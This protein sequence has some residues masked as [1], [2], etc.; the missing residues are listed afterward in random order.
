MPI[1]HIISRPYKNACGPWKQFWAARM[2]KLRCRVDIDSAD[3]FFK[4][5]DVGRG[6]DVDAVGTAKRGYRSTLALGCRGGK[7]GHQTVQGTAC[8]GD[9]AQ[10]LLNF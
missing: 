7:G 5:V 1:T 4:E 6:N 8:G 9:V 10:N 2:C 3:S